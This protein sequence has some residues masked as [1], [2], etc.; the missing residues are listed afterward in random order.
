MTRNPTPSEQAAFPTHLS[1]SCVGCGTEISLR[2]P[3]GIGGE[4]Q[5]WPCPVCGN[6]T[7]LDGSEY[8]T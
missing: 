3:D 6:P 2:H 7:R 5:G 8:I 1:G 4:G